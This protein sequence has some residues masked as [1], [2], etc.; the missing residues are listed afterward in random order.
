LV[1][2]ANEEVVAGTRR[3][4]NIVITPTIKYSKFIVNRQGLMNKLNTTYTVRMQVL[5]NSSTVPLVANKTNGTLNG[6]NGVEAGFTGEKI[7]TYAIGSEHEHSRC[8]WVENNVAGEGEIEIRLTILEGDWTNKEIPPY[9]EGVKSVGECEDNKLEIVSRKNLNLFN[10][11]GVFE[12]Y[13]TNVTYNILDSNNNI[14]VSEGAN[15]HYGLTKGII[16]QRILLERNTDYILE[17]RVDEGDAY[18]TINDYNT[19]ELIMKL[20]SKTKLI[21]LNIH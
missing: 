8:F 12:G 14:L 16:G 18:A 10:R 15:P 1:N 21:K 11:F 6:W 2:I 20:Q 3:N 5:S 17:A 9:F 7:F 13:N 19:G 4:G